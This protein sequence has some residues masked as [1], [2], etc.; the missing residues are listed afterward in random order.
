MGHGLNYDVVGATRVG[1]EHW[2]TSTPGFHRLES[3]V[4]VGPDDQ[5]AQ[6][7]E[8]I[9]RW[10]VK[11]RSGFEV[12][13]D[14]GG[15]IV[16]RPGADYTLIARLGPWSVSEPV[17]VVDVVTMPDRCGFSYG[18]RT[19]HPVRGEEGFVVYRSDGH[20]WLT[21]RSLTR[22]GEG[23]W[24]WAFP[25]ALVAQRWYRRRYARALRRPTRPIWCRRTGATHRLRAGE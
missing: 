3:T 10:A 23:R 16:V 15:S 12:T 14:A 20:V 19:G 13:P 2:R 1:S 9:L 18:T 22:A 25:A 21:L 17:C 8:D 24:R 7:C 11:T 5:W 4:H 6:I